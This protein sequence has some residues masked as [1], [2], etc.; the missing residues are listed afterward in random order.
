MKIGVI[1]IYGSKDN[2]GQLLQAFALQMF[3]KNRNH[4]AFL[5]RYDSMNRKIPLKEMNLCHIFNPLKVLNV[6]KIMLRKRRIQS[7]YHEHPRYF[8]D[9][10]RSNMQ[11]SLKEYSSR[12]ALLND[13]PDAD[14]YITGSDI[15]WS[16]K[17]PD[18]AFFLQFGSKKALRLAYAP[19]FG[20]KFKADSRNIALIA[21]YLKD[22]VFVSVRE[23]Q[24]LDICRKA[25]RED[26]TVVP[27]PVFLI[28]AEEYRKKFSLS[29][30]M[31][32][33]CLIYLVGN[34]CI[35]P[36]DEI[37][38]YARQKKLDLKFVA[39]QGVKT[40]KDYMF[41]P[42]VE[43]F[44][45]NIASAG[46]VITNSFHGCA[47][48]ILFNRPFIVLPLLHEDERLNTLLN[49]FDLNGRKYQKHFME[50]INSPMRYDKINERIKDDIIRVNAIFD[51]LNL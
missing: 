42:T 40:K 16:Y 43:E 7:S 51:S 24:G 4:N 15:V 39:S 1:T 9:F 29:V 5:I 35:V 41:W 46:L 36:W 37:E 20:F 8:E 49:A 14:V 12:E 45:Q 13:P 23:K 44:M 10:I 25:G 34:P 28:T 38:Q 19:G 30:R 6:L 22:F 32:Q 31:A 21:K 3:L 11:V 48:A 33:T 50:N 47:L 18:P 26:V 17:K 27:D 2:Y